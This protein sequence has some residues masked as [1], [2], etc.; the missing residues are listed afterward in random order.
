MVSRFRQH[1]EAMQHHERRLES[2][3]QKTLQRFPCVSAAEF[4]DL[5]YGEPALDAEGVMERWRQGRLI[6]V[7]SADR[8]IFPVFQVDARTGRLHEELSRILECFDVEEKRGGWSPYLW[9]TS[10]RPGIGDRVPARCLADEPGL[11]LR[12]IQFEASARR[13]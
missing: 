9:F 12:A 3:K 4:A 5:G 11:A 10:P 7:S 8:S 1:S 6:G 13:G 2:L